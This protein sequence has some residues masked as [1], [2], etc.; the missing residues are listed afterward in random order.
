[1]SERKGSEFIFLPFSPQTDLSISHLKAQ[2]ERFWIAER[3][4]R[5]DGRDEN[6]RRREEGGR[7]RKDREKKKKKT[8][9]CRPA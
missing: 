8:G 1:M 9:R 7:G 3:L 2:A 5:W 4:V 6:N